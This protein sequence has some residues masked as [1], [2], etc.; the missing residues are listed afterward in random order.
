MLQDAALAVR[1]FTRRDA[2]VRA[3]EQHSPDNTMRTAERFLITWG[4]PQPQV[5]STDGRFVKAQSFEQYVPSDQRTSKL[6]WSL[7]ALR[8]A[9]LARAVRE[10]LDDPAAS[11]DAH[12]ARVVAVERLMQAAPDEHT[13][14]A[15]QL[16]EL[17]LPNASH[18]DRK[19]AVAAVLPKRP[20]QAQIE[21][22]ALLAVLHDLATD[23]R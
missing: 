16:V 13:A 9:L 17:N 7:R 14:R 15:R 18:R 19:A 10:A 11:I 22:L 12:R 23:P 2:R 6:G 8:A 20:V 3:V 21:R 4:W 1:Y 5:K